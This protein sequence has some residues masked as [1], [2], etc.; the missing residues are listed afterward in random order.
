MKVVAK[1]IEVIAWFK[2]INM[3]IPIKFKLLDKDDKKTIKINKIIHTDEEKLA[4]NKM[5]IYRCQ[6]IIRE[7]ERIYELKYEVD[8]CKWYLFKI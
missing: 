5:Y 7:E 1:E 2:K 4:G 6:S 8:K 3:P